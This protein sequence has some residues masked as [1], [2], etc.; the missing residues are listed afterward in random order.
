MLM[1][2]PIVWTLPSEVRSP[3][4]LFPSP[5]SSYHLA[6]NH[7]LKI[8]ELHGI[9]FLTEVFVFLEKEKWDSG[10]CPASVWETATSAPRH[11]SWVPPSNSTMCK[12]NYVMP[13]EVISCLNLAKVDYIVGELKLVS[14]HRV[15]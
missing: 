7:Q 4:T 2:F 11:R 13:L 10:V 9:Y 8:Q 6:I 5:S 12:L 14:S 1:E 15:I 3:E